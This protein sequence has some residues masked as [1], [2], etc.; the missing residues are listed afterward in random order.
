MKNYRINKNTWHNPNDNH[1][2]HNETCSKYNKLELF[3]TLGRF[4]TCQEAIT[5]ARRRNYTKVDGCRECC[6]DCHLEK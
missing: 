5:E 4:Q 1:E 2:V 3:E 6:Y